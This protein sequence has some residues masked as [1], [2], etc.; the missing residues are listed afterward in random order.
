MVIDDFKVPIIKKGIS[1]ISSLKNEFINKK[2]ILFGVPGA[3]T[4][5][6][7]EKHLPGYIKL[8]NSHDRFN[9]SSYLYVLVK[10][11]SSDYKIKRI[12][13]NTNDIPKVFVRNDLINII[14]TDGTV[15]LA[16]SYNYTEI[17]DSFNSALNSNKLL[18]VESMYI[19][20]QFNV[21][22][23]KNG[24]IAN[25]GR[26]VSN[27]SN[28]TQINSNLEI[29]NH[30]ILFKFLNTTSPALLTPAQTLRV[31]FLRYPRTFCAMPDSASVS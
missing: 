21:A 3:F 31:N 25:W 5:T 15:I 9:S 23:K 14:R 13:K 4:P 10:A 11:S 1:S 7:S 20:Y 30:T 24:R 18:G 8:Y 22:L 12:N 27:Y 26:D 16:Q 29:V 19:T 28:F 2:I 17:L 6:C